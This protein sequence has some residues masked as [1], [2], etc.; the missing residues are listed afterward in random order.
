[1][2]IR[3]ID[4]QDAEA[5]LRLS[6]RAWAPVFDSITERI[7]PELYRGLHPTG[8]QASQRAAVEASLAEQAEWVAERDNAPIGFVSIVLHDE[9]RSAR[10]DIALAEVREIGL[11]VITSR[12]PGRSDS[13]CRGPA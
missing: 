9:D 3:P 8:W 2:R 1:M 12:C 4:D 5:L 13:V 7:D 11:D 10:N 6:L